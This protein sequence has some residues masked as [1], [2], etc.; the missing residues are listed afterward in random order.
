[1]AGARPTSLDTRPEA[2]EIQL[3]LL[4]EAGAGRRASLLL[5]LS[6]WMIRTS[7]RAVARR[8][9]NLDEREATLLWVE[10]HYGPAIASRLRAHLDARP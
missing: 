2:E 5:S 4:R 1:M 6:S 7:R 8:H 9:P 3:R 10:L